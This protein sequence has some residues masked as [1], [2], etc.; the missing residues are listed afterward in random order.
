MRK[1]KHKTTWNIAYKN[2]NGC[3]YVLED[4]TQFPETLPLWVVENSN[5][6]EEVKEFPKI[7][8]FRNKCNNVI[9]RL[10]EN[11]KYSSAGEFGYFSKEHHLR[12]DY[13]EIEK[14]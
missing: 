7:I 1:F 13:Y 12:L 9:F 14:N 11:G 10:C 6:W 3:N 4:G 5:D 2:K 8:S